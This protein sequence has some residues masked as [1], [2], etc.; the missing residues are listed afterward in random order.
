[1]N[2][3]IIQVSNLRLRAEIHGSM[4]LASQAS[5]RVR[6]SGLGFGVH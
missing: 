3:E 2:S 1:M 4:S 5:F 6:V